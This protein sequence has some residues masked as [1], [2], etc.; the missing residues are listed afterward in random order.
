VNIGGITIRPSTDSQVHISVGLRPANTPIW[1]LLTRKQ[2]P[3]AMLTATIG[4]SIDKG[5]LTLTMDYPEHK[6]SNDVSEDWVVELPAADQVGAQLNI[7]KLDVSDMTGGISGKLNIGKANLDVP[8]GPLDVSVNIGKITAQAG[9]AMYGKVYLAADVGD[10]KM[11]VNGLTVGDRQ[12]QGTGSQMHYQGK[13]TD[14]INLTVN[15]GKVS[16]SLADEQ[17]QS[18]PAGK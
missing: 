2:V 6:G 15:T 11:K 7:G 14:A 16:L 13:G 1:G 5:V 4:H 12:H 9:T 8:K 3:K 10:T 17:K 18:P